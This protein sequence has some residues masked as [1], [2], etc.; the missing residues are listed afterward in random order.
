MLT[1]ARFSPFA[2]DGRE[3]L[4]DCPAPRAV[5]NGGPREEG[6]GSLSSAVAAIPEESPS[7]SDGGPMASVLFSQSLAD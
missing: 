3:P 2:E 6:E 5:A 7:Q 4:I 1:R